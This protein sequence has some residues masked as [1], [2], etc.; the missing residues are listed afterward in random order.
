MHQ[1]QS[2]FEQLTN[3]FSGMPSWW[4]CLQ[5]MCKIT[6]IA[7]IVI[8]CPILAYSRAVVNW[9]SPSNSMLQ[10]CD[11]PWFTGCVQLHTNIIWIIRHL[12]KRGTCTCWQTTSP[13]GALHFT[14]ISLESLELFF[15]AISRALFSFC[16]YTI[17]CT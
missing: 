8:M 12:V 15:V 16:M 14:R 1:N 6:P 11:F 3:D 4:R 13:L 10:S 5:S 9:N 17:G 2:E 7:L